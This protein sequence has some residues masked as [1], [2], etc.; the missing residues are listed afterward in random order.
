[1]L[2]W[3]SSQLDVRWFDFNTLFLTK[4]MI[5][6]NRAL[7]SKST[8]FFVILG[9]LLIFVSLI[10]SSP[11]GVPV[12]IS[13]LPDKSKIFLCS[14]NEQKTGRL[15]FSLN[16]FSD[17]EKNIG[18]EYQLKISNMSKNK[19]PE[20]TEKNGIFSIIGEFSIG[21]LCRYFSHNRYFYKCD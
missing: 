6:K 20:T 8:Y 9:S 1:M 15:K 17:Y 12:W 19:Q 16:W 5:L 2:C 14:A 3:P 11:F 13:S 18:A 21:I 10:I 4:A 7:H